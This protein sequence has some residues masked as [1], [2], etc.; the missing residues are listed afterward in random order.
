M[1]SVVAGMSPSAFER[2]KA[3]SVPG[4]FLL[5]AAWICFEAL[6]VP[7]G[8]F[9]M[10]GAG[11]FPLAL[12]LALG[13]FAVMLL[14]MSL[15]SPASGS[16]DAWP[17]RRDGV[18]LVASVVA[19]VWLFERA[20]FLLTMALFLALTT[21]VLGK[22]SWLTAVVLALVGSVTAYVVFSRV[23]LIAL[24]SGILPF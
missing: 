10:P 14:G 19:A 6:Q 12:G 23:L 1:S 11:F 2:V 8:S 9:R 17:E 15:L 13:M 21:R 7:L 4:V 3:G 5:L 18:Y 24:P 16:T 22:I 20:G